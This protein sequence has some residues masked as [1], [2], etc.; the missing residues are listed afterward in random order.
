MRTNHFPKISVGPAVA[1]IVFLVSASAA[2][3]HCQ[4]PC[5]IYDD[6]HMVDQMMLDAVTI[7]KSVTEIDKLSGKSDPQSVNQLVRWVENKDDHANNTITIIAEYFLTQRVKPSQSDYLERLA[8]HHAVMVAAMQAKQNA[9]G[10][11]AEALE[12]AV[13]AL[14]VYYPKHDHDHDH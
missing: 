6:S 11:H 2:S 9:D 3:A 1:V 7:K 8:N 12:K 5:G 13:A 14:R 10:Q 4:I